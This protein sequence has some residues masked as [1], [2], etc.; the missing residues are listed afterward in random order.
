MPF[1]AW[2]QT[3]PFPIICRRPVR[4]HSVFIKSFLLHY[5]EKTNTTPFQGRFS[6]LVPGTFTHNPTAV[7]CNLATGTTGGS[8]NL[9]EFGVS[10]ETCGLINC[11]W[12][13]GPW[14]HHG[15]YVCTLS[16]DVACVSFQVWP[17]QAHN[18][19][20]QLASTSKHP[21]GPTLPLWSSSLHLPLYVTVFN[22]HHTSLHVHTSTHTPQTHR[23]VPRW[24]FT[25]RYTVRSFSRSRF[26]RLSR[27]S[28]PSWIMNCSR[29]TLEQSVTLWQLCIWLCIRQMWQN[30]AV[31]AQLNLG[32]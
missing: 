15:L 31:L 22:L 3:L 9:V 25:F 2:R 10:N 26:A 12:G 16:W 27:P 30:N 7:T 29:E 17:L 11:V 18:V 1:I 23:T 19:L 28:R 4:R 24:V 8:G 32:W 21:H 5:K 6:E 14:L 13:T 20:M